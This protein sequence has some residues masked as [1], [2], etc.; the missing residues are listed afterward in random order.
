MLVSALA[1]L[2]KNFCFSSYG[3]VIQKYFCNWGGERAL[4][5]ESSCVSGNNKYHAKI[6][7]LID[8]LYKWKYLCLI[9]LKM[10]VENTSIHCDNKPV[11]I[12]FEQ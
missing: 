4:E 9:V 2:F 11:Q 10:W 5:T 8:V 3:F 6:S 12:I 7:R 1:V